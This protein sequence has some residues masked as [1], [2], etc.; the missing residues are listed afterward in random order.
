MIRQLKKNFNPG[1][2]VTVRTCR[3]KD[4]GDSVGLMRLGRM[5]GVL[6]RIEDTRCWSCRRDALLHE[7]AHAMEWSAHWTDDSPKKNHGETWG[8]WYSKIYTHLIEECWD[9]M[10][11]LKLL[12]LEQTNDDSNSD[13]VQV[14]KRRLS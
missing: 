12:S 2:P 5:V 8:V 6:I 7:W 13:P 3:M 9:E 14:D 4:S 1:V 10:K 11:R